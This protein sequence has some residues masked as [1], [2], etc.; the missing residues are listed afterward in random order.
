MANQSGRWNFGQMIGAIMTGGSLLLGFVILFRDHRSRE[1]AQA[2]RF[3]TFPRR[4]KGNER[5][6]ELFIQNTSDHPIFRVTNTH[7]FKARVLGIKL[8]IWGGHNFTINGEPM[9]EIPVVPPGHQA[10]LQFDKIDLKPDAKNYIVF[11]DARSKIWRRD[12]VTQKYRRSSGQTSHIL[13]I[14]NPGI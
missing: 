2:D 1:R 9:R 10:V 8:D 3:I 14:M 4:R 6:F 5:G 13:S 12:V 7:S 11:T